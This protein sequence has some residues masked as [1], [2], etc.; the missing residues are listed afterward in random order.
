L[1][2]ERCQPFSFPLPSPPLQIL[3]ASSCSLLHILTQEV[4][5]MEQKRGWQNGSNPH[6]KREK[7]NNIHITVRVKGYESI[8]RTFDTKGEA[9]IW[10][11]E[12]S[13]LNRKGDRSNRSLFFFQG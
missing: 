13:G 12:I 5:Q 6:K 1:K 10:A 4:K 7:E 3:F 11:A 9:R 8:S 2:I